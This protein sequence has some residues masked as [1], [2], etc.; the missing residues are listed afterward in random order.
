MTG[1]TDALAAGPIVIDG[2]LGTLLETRGHDLSSSLWSARLLADD[3][4]AIR[5]GHAEFFAAG[6]RIAITSSYQVSYEALAVEGFTRA[7][8]DTLLARSVELARGARADAGLTEEQAWVAA[9]IGPYGACL[10]DGSEYTGDYGLS[11][12]QL[13]QWHRPR[14]L[15]LAAARP[16]AFAIETMPS[17]AEVEAVC[18][19]IAGHGIPAW[20]SMTIAGQTLRSGEALAE[21]CTIAASTDEVVAVGVNCCDPRDVA[22]ALAVAHAVTGL[23]TVAYPNSGETWHADSRAWSGRAQEISAMVGPWAGAG[24]R[25]IGGCC[26]IGPAAIADIQQ[27][28]ALR[29]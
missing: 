27:A 11:I 23:P 2:G 15:A 12:E 10:A 13:R 6:A 7:E 9:S 25:L 5:R 24:A 26:G 29:A 18:A 20:V 19:E 4:D 1:F 8:V 17:H 21:A 16:D 28:L 14:I 22:P 3:P